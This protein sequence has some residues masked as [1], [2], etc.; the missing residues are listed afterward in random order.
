MIVLLNGT[1]V[2]VYGIDGLGDIKVTERRRDEDRKLSKS[3]SSELT[4][5]G[6]GFEIIRAAL[7]DNPAGKLEKVDV[8]VYDDCCEGNEEGE[9][10]LVFEGVIR[11]DSIDWCEGE[12]FVKAQL[13]ESTEETRKIDCVKSTLVW[14]NHEGFLEEDHPRVVYC[15]E[16][17]PSALQ[18][19][20]MI[21]GILLNI[22]FLVLYPTV[23]VVWL[24]VEILNT[25]IDVINAII[26]AI[27]TIP[28]I[29]IDNIDE[30]DIDGN[31]DTNLMEEWQNM[32]DRL[33]ENIIGC[34]REHPSPLVRRYIENACSKC[35]ISFESSIFTDPNS[36]YYNTL[37]FNAPVEKGT[38]DEDV[39][40]IEANH[41]IKNLEIFLKD[42]LPVFQADYEIRN[43]VLRFERE[44]FF[45]TAT[46]WLS[47]GDLDNA[48]RV[49]ERLCY[50]WRDEK[51]PAYGDFRYSDDAVDWVGNEARN[52]YNDIVEFNSPPNDL[53]VGSREIYLPF[54]MAR[55]RGD[56]IDRDVL[57]DY[58]WW[59]TWQDVIQEFDRSLLMNNGTAFQ[60]KLLIWDGV[61]ISNAKIRS[62]DIPGQ[63]VP[64]DENFNAPFFFNEYNLAPNT[65]YPQDLENG[66][67]YARF[68]SYK[69]PRVLSD[70]GLE[71]TFAFKFNCDHLRNRDLYGN[72]SLPAGIGRIRE[73]EIDYANR[74]MTVKGNL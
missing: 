48:G 14:D 11:G 20:V 13:V 1:Q 38:R 29:N 17:R 9:P 21:I 46:P 32:I 25:I 22:A 2:N 41:P 49:V 56:G 73:I 31:E 59:P 54:G 39:L 67:L 7:I 30:I 74:V 57:A 18:D 4:F 63:D 72:V 45:W 15:L 10:I 44:D 51:S 12:C 6:Q 66:S 58:D 47:Y 40:W 33:N 24:I 5:Y 64:E 69:H 62:F 35:G 61:S 37:Y 65:G 28:G 27:N 55:H 16:Y 8:L 50:K 71:F 23:A 26:D 43:G 36:D 19:V 68:H 34:G 3:F 42:L 70:R 53:Q 60:P 52:R